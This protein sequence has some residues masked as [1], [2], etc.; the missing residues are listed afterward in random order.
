[1]GLLTV[2]CVK[3]LPADSNQQL[4]P[5][6]RLFERGTQY[7]VTVLNKP[8]NPL[9]TLHVSPTRHVRITAFEKHHPSPLTASWAGYIWKKYLLLLNC[10]FWGP[11]ATPEHPLSLLWV[12]SCQPPILD[13]S[14]ISEKQVLQTPAHGNLSHGVENPTFY[15]I[16][17]QKPQI[18]LNPS[19]PRH[20]HHFLCFPQSVRSLL[21][22]KHNR[23]YLDWYKDLA[24]NFR[25]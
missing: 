15:P 19:L 23:N 13:I 17:P 3:P 20:P 9:I 10:L 18:F 1:M 8:P 4:K 22:Q 12:N 2:T 5:P 6:L 7:L 24:D 25:R 11:S 14:N 16:K 21:L